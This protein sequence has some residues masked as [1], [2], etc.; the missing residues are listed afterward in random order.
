MVAERTIK[1][2]EGVVRHTRVVTDEDV[3]G[4]DLLTEYEPAGREHTDKRVDGRRM[5][6]HLFFVHIV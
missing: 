3:R 6:I 4:L 5:R 1:E 2:E